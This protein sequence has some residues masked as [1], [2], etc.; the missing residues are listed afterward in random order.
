MPQGSE[1]KYWCLKTHNYISAVP[2][3][4]LE[5]M[6]E[7]QKLQERFQVAPPRYPWLDIA[8]GFFCQTAI[9]YLSWNYGIVPALGFAKAIGIIQAFLIVL[10]VGFLKLRRS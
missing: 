2:I 10:F 8:I 5:K 4:A 6:K 9:V 3:W 1:T 7:R